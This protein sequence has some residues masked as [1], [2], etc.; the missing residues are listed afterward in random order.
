MS[1]RLARFLRRVPRP[2]DA[3]RTPVRQQD[4]PSLEISQA[5][6]PIAR[7][8]GASERAFFEGS[9]MIW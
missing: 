8:C 9:V 4:L 1:E 3:A 2:R 6:I 7:P 5:V